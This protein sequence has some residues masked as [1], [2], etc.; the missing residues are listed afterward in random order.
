MRKSALIKDV[1]IEEISHS[2]DS[3]DNFLAGLYILIIEKQIGSV[4]S[5][6]LKQNIIARGG[7]VLSSLHNSVRASYRLHWVANR[8]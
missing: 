4:R 2:N 8:Y 6:V 5:R 1:K 3:K 7:I